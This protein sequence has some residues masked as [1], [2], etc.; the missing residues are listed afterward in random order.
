MTRDD[1]LDLLAA[2]VAADRLAESEARAILRAWETD[3][4]TDDDLPASPDDE[5]LARIILPLL[6]LGLESIATRFVQLR[7]ALRVLAGGTSLEERD[8]TAR[9]ILDASGD[10][11]DARTRRLF[12]ARDGAPD[13]PPVLGSV[14]RWH[15]EART[16][17]ADDLAA[18]ARLGF[19]NVPGD[20]TTILARA[21]VQQGD[22]LDR[23][24]VRITLGRV[25]PANGGLRALTEA[26]TAARL[27]SYAGVPFATFYRGAMRPASLGGELGPG[28]VLDYISLDDGGTCVPCLRAERS[29]PYVPG[30]PHPMPGGVCLGR[31]HC[32]CKLAPRFSPTDYDRLTS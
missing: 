18:L 27:R 21:V 28:W 22:H 16:A 12:T 19:V 26:E 23:F 14:R 32:R 5:A 8:A 2:L 30:T 13:R 4:I 11:G 20:E 15:D 17:V 29:G 10:A 7:A 9:A 25:G 1:V 31:G 24:A 6:A 3:A